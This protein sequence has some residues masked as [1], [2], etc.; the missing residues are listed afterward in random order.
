MSIKLLALDL[1]GTIVTK[2]HTI[3]ERTQAA[4]K[5]AVRRGV[6]VVIA[7]GREYPVTKKFIQMLELT[8]PVICYQG[9]LIYDF[10][11]DQIIASETVPLPLAYQLIDQA[12]AQRLA[13][14]LYLGHQAYTEAP[15]ELSR[16]LLHTAGIYPQEVN[17]LKLVT[18]S[19]PFK[20]LIVHPAAEAGIITAQLAE[21]LD[22][23]LSVFQSFDTLIEVTSPRVSKGQALATLAN[24]YG[25]AQ[26]EVMAIGDQDNDIDMI[27]WAGLGIAMG[28]ASAGAKAAADTIAPPIEAEGAA[29]AIETF[30]LEQTLPA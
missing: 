13:L 10:Q 2:L 11:A 3:P 15:T 1:D 16:N 7:T 30:I 20:G 23:A 22:G 21:A 29:W 19:A 5:V 12:R 18:T 4:I 26:D 14:H 25:L 9:A 27:A 17:D 28:N 24:Y 8:T 6:R